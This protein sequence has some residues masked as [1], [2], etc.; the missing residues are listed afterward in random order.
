M[1]KF[2][3]IFGICFGSL[4]VF[5]GGFL[6]VKYLIGD[7]NP[8]IIQPDSIK[9]EQTDYYFD[10]DMALGDSDDLNSCFIRSKVISCGFKNL[11]VAAGAQHS[12][13]FPFT[14]DNFT[15]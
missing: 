14:K 9:F 2:L 3:A 1:K 11:A 5:L 12:V 6:G 10:Y 4:V 13:Q 7:F 15:G 8:V